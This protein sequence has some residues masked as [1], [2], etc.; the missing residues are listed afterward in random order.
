MSIS[1]TKNV[2]A[3][4]WAGVAAAETGARFQHLGSSGKQ[5]RAAYRRGFELGLVA[6]KE[7]ISCSAAIAKYEEELK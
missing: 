7:G 5:A 6:S 2:A 4:Y 1:E 3:G